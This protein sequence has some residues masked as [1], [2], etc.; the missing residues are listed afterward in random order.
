MNTPLLLRTPEACE[1]LA[2]SRSALYAFTARL[3]I[4]PVKIGSATRWRRSDLLAAIGQPSTLATSNT[5]TAAFRC[6]GGAVGGSDGAG[7]VGSGCSQ[8]GA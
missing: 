5:P 3:G 7:N 6:E 4:K 2:I 8:E 1:L